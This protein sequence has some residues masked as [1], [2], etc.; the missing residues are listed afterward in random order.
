VTAPGREPD[1]DHEPARFGG[2]ADEARLAVL[3]VVACAGTFTG[4]RLPTRSALIGAAALTA[5]LAG[6]V[7][8][9][10]KGFRATS[11]TGRMIAVLMIALGV[12]CLRGGQAARAYR[13]LE[14]RSLRA[15]AIVRGDPEPIGVGWRAELQ[16][17]SGDR[18]EATAFGRAGFELRQLAVGD[19][20]LA[21]GRV[22]PIGD[23]PWLRAR[24]IVGRLTLDDVAVTA[25]AAGFDRLVNELRSVIV[26]GAVSFDDRARPLYTGLV[27][28]DDRFQP[29]AQQA[30]FRAS[31]LTHLL[32]VSGQ[33]V[34][35]VLLVVRPVLLAFGR[36]TRLVAIVGILILF[37]AMTRAEPSV[38]RASTT[39][40]VA[41]W[42]LVTGR[43]GSGLRTLSVGVA[44][45]VL[46][47]PFLLDVVGFQ[48]SVAASAGIVVVSP[49]VLGRL[50]GPMRRL[51]GMTAVGQAL[52]VTV[53]AQAAVAPLLIHH[54]GPLPLAS[55]P[56]NL[57]AGWAAGAVMTLG[58]TVGPISGLLHR[59]RFPVA[60]ELVQWPSRLL[61]GWV[62]GTAR[63]AADL[64]LPRLGLPS[65]AAL[66]VLGILVAVRPRGP[67]GR[68]V[69]VG[70]TVAVGGV[71]AG[72]MSHVRDRPSMIADGVLHIPSGSA[73]GGS[74]GVLVISDP[75][76]S[77]VDAVLASGVDRVDVVV[78]ERGDAVSA[79]IVGAVIDV[80]DAAT[81]LAPPDHRIRG[82]TRVTEPMVV[83]TSW[84]LVTVEP[85]STGSALIVTVPAIAK[86]DG[87]PDG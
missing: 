48:L 51:P 78:T 33:N 31:G 8:M 18:V 9:L 40:G 52:A 66:A 19:R 2:A 54:F 29:L 24:H 27:I 16:L 81:V 30:Q 83:S 26:D 61:V 65:L 38:L 72:A 43:A 41:T 7:F 73:D 25:P 11:T 64:D 63:W 57:V 62:D 3:A 17:R 28:G 47:D 55:I 70:A 80:I 77:A 10:A 79:R 76:P 12:T 4:L 46:V 6:I 53:G 75:A 23:R 58:L 84:G 60:A 68:A 34:A 82:A 21:V 71:L 50:P 14:A 85:E 74:G 32:A 22:R 20:V 42:A 45:L 37:A 67:L 86:P 36:R 69:V 39:A 87:W 56:A 13:P 15:E 5:A 49:L 35:F 1:G 59:A 44:G